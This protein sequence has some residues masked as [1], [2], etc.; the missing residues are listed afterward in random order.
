[1]S[2]GIVKISLKPDTFMPKK[3]RNMVEHGHFAKRARYGCREFAQKPAAA[4]GTA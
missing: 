1:M 3:H 2:L 4:I